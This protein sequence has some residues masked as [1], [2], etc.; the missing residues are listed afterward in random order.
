MIFF[1]N[2]CNRFPNGSW[3]SPD[4]RWEDL[5]RRDARRMDWTLEGEQLSD[6]SLFYDQALGL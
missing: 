1:A 3:H 6:V 5:Q 4:P 2:D